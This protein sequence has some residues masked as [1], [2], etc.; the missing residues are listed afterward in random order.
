MKRFLFVCTGNTCRSP[1]AE[2]LLKHK[3]NE[4]IE[5]K[6]AGVSA[7]P[8]SDASFGTRTVLKEKGIDSNHS[9][10][11]IDNQLVSWADVILTMTEKHKK[12]LQLQ[13]PEYEGNIYTL[14]E[15]VE[16]DASIEENQQQ[17]NRLYTEMELKQAEFMAENKEKIEKL[18]RED[19][20][21]AKKKLQLIEQQLNL[22]I[23]P[24]RKA[25]EEFL[26]NAPSND[27]GDPFGGSVDVYRE[28]AQE[29]EL[30]IDQLKKKYL[31]S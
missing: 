21:E 8:G 31:S 26:E 20:V 2:A 24:H 29:I 27:I 10:Q 22:L 15:F 7:F 18:E 6:S 25:I 30:L 1:L 14:K 23:Q 9:A 12:V 28:T 16:E 4:E 5:V 17:L 11:N 19:T 3:T 13:F